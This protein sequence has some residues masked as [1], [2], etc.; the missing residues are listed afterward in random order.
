VCVCDRGMHENTTHLIGPAE[1]I[2]ALGAIAEIG[3]CPVVV[4]HHFLHESRVAG[5]LHRLAKCR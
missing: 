3:H 1:S 4:A 5:H 2:E